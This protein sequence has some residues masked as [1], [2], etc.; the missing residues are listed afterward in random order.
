MA[1]RGSV[2]PL[3]VS[4]IKAGRPLTVTDPAMTRFL[5]S[6]DQ[7]VELVL[8]AYENAAQGD[9]F[10]QKAPAETVAVI[11]QAMCEMHSVGTIPSARSARGMARRSM[12]RY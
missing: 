1:S 5:M 11:A 9:I 10:V 8:F 3:F 7:S 4:Q 6:L 12:N 2:I